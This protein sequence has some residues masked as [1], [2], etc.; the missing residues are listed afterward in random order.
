MAPLVLCQ[1]EECGRAKPP[2]YAGGR[3]C[4]ECFEML[5]NRELRTPMV[6]PDALP[7][8]K[9]PEPPSK[10]SREKSFDGIVRRKPK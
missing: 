1:C 7:A 3:I 8:E 6:E 5:R 4:R 2:Y 9:W 10:T